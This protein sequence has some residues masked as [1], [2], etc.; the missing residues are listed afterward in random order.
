MM[1]DSIPRD[2]SKLPATH[3]TAR[4]IESPCDFCTSSG[5]SPPRTAIVDGRTLSGPWGYMCR[6]HYRLHGVGLGTGRGQ[7]LI[8]S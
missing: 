7:V 3:R 1:P 4:C 2:L 6:E 5:Y 8:P